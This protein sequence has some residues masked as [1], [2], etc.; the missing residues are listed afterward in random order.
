MKEAEG[1]INEASEI[2]QEV[3]IETYGSMEKK[4]KAEFILEQ[5]RLT[6][7]QRDFVRTGILANKLNR[8][9]LDEEGFEEIR[10]RY[11]DLLALLAHGRHDAIALAKGYNSVLATRG[12]ADDEN[13]WRPAL[14]SA[15]M[16]TALSSYDNEVSD[17]LHR[18]KGDKRVE[19]LPSFAELLRLLTTSEVI[20][21]P[22]PSPH[23]EALR[24]HSAFIIDPNTIGAPG[25][26]G[27]D[28]PEANVIEPGASRGSGSSA[29]NA[30]AAATEPAAATRASSSGASSAAAGSSAAAS[31]SSSA[32][33][34]S[35]AAGSGSSTLS[36]SIVTRPSGALQSSI[37]L[38]EDEPRSQWWP[39]FRKRIVQ[40]NIRVIAGAYSRIKFDRLANILDLDAP[41]T[42]A[43]V[44]ELVSSK[45]IYGRIDR[46]AGI[47]V[48][49]RPRPAT[50]V[51]TDWAADLE[52]VLNLVE[53]TSH[54]IQKEYMVHGVA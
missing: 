11:F 44:S 2:L 33:A 46:P 4:E 53:K 41:T 24:A 49:E 22:L 42:E 15:I 32:S 51:L 31:S 14:A 3:Q 13:K 36:A 8:K 47:V 28:A 35:A 25:G 7:R 43:M 50:E 9:V 12:F 40:H 20:P 16:Y 5:T 39:I 21:W 29:S 27:G 52:S 17:L 26:A 6:I 18:L 38:K 10:L 23:H 19:E 34:S 37:V 30:A 54:L 45:S 1:K 48:F